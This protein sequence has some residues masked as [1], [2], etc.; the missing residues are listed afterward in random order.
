MAAR[1]LC[2]CGCGQAVKEGNRFVNYHARTGKRHSLKTRR[3]ISK[4]RT[5]WKTSKLTRRR[6]SAAH[7]GIPRFKKDRGVSG[8]VGK[9]EKEGVKVEAGA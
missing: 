9:V 6:M 2:E 1:V 5:G 8:K 4:S 3:K 7:T